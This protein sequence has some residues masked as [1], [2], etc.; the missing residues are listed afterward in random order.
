MTQHF[1][2]QATVRLP[3][4]QI[5]GKVRKPQSWLPL[6]IVKQIASGLFVTGRKHDD[7]GLRGGPP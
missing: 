7:A 6:E 5:G 4:N 3:E 2:E 1:L